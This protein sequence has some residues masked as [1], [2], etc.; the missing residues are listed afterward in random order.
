MQTVRVEYNKIDSAPDI[1]MDGSPLAETASLAERIYTDLCIWVD[2]FF[3]FMDMQLADPYV[4]KLIG[5]KYHEIAFNSAKARSRYCVGLDFTELEFRIPVV[6]K[7]RFVQQ[8]NNKYRVLDGKMSDCVAINCAGVPEFSKYCYEN[9]A[10]T[11]ESSDFTLAETQMGEASSRYTIIIS[12]TD[13]IV[14]RGRG[15]EI[16]VTEKNIQTLIEYINL[17]CVWLKGINRF[18][19][20]LAGYDINPEDKTELDAYINETVKVIV[21]NIPAE[22]DVGQSIDIPVRIYP[23]NTPLTYVHAESNN[24]YLLN[25]N[26]LSVTGL[27]PG[28][29]ELAIKNDAGHVFF[30]TQIRVIQHNYITNLAINMKEFK[31]RVGGILSF[32][33]A[34]APESAEDIGMIEVTVNNS[35]IAMITGA[36]E[37]HALA[38]GRIVITAR[39]KNV[40]RRVFVSI[41]PEVAGLTLPAEELNL[42]LNA[43]ATM[44]CAY[45]PADAFPKPTVEWESSNPNVVYVEEDGDYGCILASG[46][47]CGMATITCRIPNS[48]ISK[49]M[50]VVV[51]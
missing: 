38:P 42:P 7:Y 22:I 36:Y 17:Y 40:E 41:Y 8:M 19:R 30:K 14:Q 51:Y 5:H 25:C 11:N 26:G 45:Y 34:A 28:T 37:L 46:R 43:Y 24:M 23:R 49:S 9:V 29:C 50:T 33:V 47:N 2:S 31:V 1:L 15:A 6:E 39:S 21:P 44:G 35:N 13:R 18:K 48:Q 32:S 20:A 27:Y 12:D 10:F 4:V 16:Y 3:D